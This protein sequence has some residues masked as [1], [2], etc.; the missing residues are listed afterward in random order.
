MIVAVALVVLLGMA[1][2][3]I[4]LGY[5]YVIRNELQ[6]AAD[7]GALAGAQVLYTAAPQGAQVNPGAN[8]TARALIESNFSEN[9]AV[10]VQSIERG[11]WSFTTRTFT[12]NDSLQPT[13]L[14]G[15]TTAQLDVDT[16][17]INAVRVITQRRGTAS[18]GIAP[19][20]FARIFGSPSQP[21]TATAVAY[22][23]YAGTL[24]PGEADQPIAICKQGITDPVTGVY[25]CGVGRMINSGQGNE[26]HQTGGWTNFSQPCE[27]ANANSVRPLVCGN[28][29]PEP[30]VLGVTMGTQGG[31][32]Q[33][34][35]DRLMNC[36]SNNRALDTDGDTIPDRPWSMTLPVIDCPGN[37]VGPCSEVV[38]AVELN[39][40]WI[41]RNDRNQYREVPRKM[42][43]P[44]TERTWTCSTTATT[45][46]AGRTCWNEFVQEF[47]LRDVLNQSPAFYE[48]KT[49]YFIPDCKPH[50]PAGTTGG[51]NFGILA[52]IPVLVQ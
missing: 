44:N 3:A 15:V 29:N 48:D 20:F 4:D 38:G 45:K 47:N 21:I 16:N 10:E 30:V 52:R 2:L 37:N 42:Y 46:E 5:Y 34:T 24:G 6:N 36:W 27:T 11:H 49:I 26:G 1:A 43:N 7:A 28:G 31:E 41:T 32:Q 8:D 35:Y 19:P 33:T 9:S 13:S 12:P 23:G 51:Q 22:V 50:V 18:G 39:V 25:S 17:F 40:V 14:W